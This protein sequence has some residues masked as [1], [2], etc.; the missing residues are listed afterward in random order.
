MDDETSLTQQVNA[1]ARRG[2][3]VMANLPGS[4]A[5]MSGVDS[6]RTLSAETAARAVTP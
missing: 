1:P 4:A 3:A 5:T 2:W 6:S